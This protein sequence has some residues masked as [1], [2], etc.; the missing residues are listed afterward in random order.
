MPLAVLLALQ[1]VW[2]ERAGH[3]GPARPVDRQLPALGCARTPNSTLEHWCVEVPSAFTW[4]GL[5]C[6]RGQYLGL[7]ILHQLE[8]WGI[9][10]AALAAI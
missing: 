10:G 4:D 7:V 2:A 9:T 1:P 3:A 5:P 8:R 6:H